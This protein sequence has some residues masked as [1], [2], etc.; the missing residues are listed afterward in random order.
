MSRQRSYEYRMRRAVAKAA[1]PH[2]GAFRDPMAMRM[3]AG[4]YQVDL[5][6][7]TRQTAQRVAEHEALETRTWQVRYLDPCDEEQTLEVELTK[8]LDEW[9]A[10]RA[11][12]RMLSKEDPWV[13]EDDW[14][15]LG[16]VDAA[17]LPDEPTE[18]E[19][20]RPTGM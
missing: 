5:A 6:D 12:R 11:A 7:L 14:K 8:S 19:P 17:S 4:E 20:Y 10:E 16:V 1:Q 18:P 15:I 2:D 9:D 3:I 13:E